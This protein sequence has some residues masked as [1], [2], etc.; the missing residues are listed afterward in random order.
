MGVL[1]VIIT[2]HEREREGGDVL[3]E[4]GEGVV[5][6]YQVHVLEQHVDATHGDQVHAEG[7]VPVVFIAGER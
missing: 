2:P 5:E 3:L 6:P 1:G 4:V 7:L